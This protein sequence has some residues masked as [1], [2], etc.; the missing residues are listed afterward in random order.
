M[1][2]EC[3]VALA[4]GLLGASGCAAPAA[5]APR[6]APAVEVRGA[7]DGIRVEHEYRPERPGDTLHA[8]AF[9]HPPRAYF[10]SCWGKWGAYD[11]PVRWCRPVRRCN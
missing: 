4:L 6:T 11:A 7:A 2:N 5:P 9:D 3:R 1:K 8:V 10:A